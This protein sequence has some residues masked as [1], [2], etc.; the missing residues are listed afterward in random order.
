MQQNIDCFLI[1]MHSVSTDGGE[2]NIS[3]PS[4]A[5]HTRNKIVLMRRIVDVNFPFHLVGEAL[6]ISISLRRHRNVECT[7]FSRR[8]D[9][10]CHCTCA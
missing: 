6:D 4:K 2:F 8:L 5:A 10:E 1:H 7:T 9:T 3:L